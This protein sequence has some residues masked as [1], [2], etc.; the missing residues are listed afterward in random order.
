MNRDVKALLAK[1][2]KKHK[3]I[4]TELGLARATV[5]GVIAG[6]SRSEKIERYIATLG[7]RR[8]EKLWGEQIARSS[9]KAA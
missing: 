9:R 5:S 6:H 1:I 7:G 4:A 8:Y 3:D 2:G